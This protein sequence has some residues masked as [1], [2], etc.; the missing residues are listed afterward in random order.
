MRCVTSRFSTTRG[1]P[2]AANTTPTGERLP[3]P[4]LTDELAVPA[5]VVPFAVAE[6]ESA[7]PKVGLRRRNESSIEI[8]AEKPFPKVAV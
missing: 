8:V 3:W 1:T 6:S 2:F 4:R 5:G 7:K